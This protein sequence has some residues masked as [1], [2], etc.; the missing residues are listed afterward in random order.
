MSGDYITGV[1]NVFA[2]MCNYDNINKHRPEIGIRPKALIG[3]DAVVMINKNV[4]TAI[5]EQYYRTL[6]I[7]M[8]KEKSMR[9]NRK[10]GYNRRI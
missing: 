9:H 4:D 5:V 2:Q 7:I 8:S 1:V 3:D 6:G 10:V